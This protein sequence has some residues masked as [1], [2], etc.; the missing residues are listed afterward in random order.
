MQLCQGMQR[1][2]GAYNSLMSFTSLN[3]LGN[4]SELRATTQFIRRRV[5]EF[6]RGYA[7]PRVATV[8]LAF[9]NGSLSRFLRSVPTQ[10]AART[11]IQQKESAP[12]YRHLVLGH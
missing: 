5:E 8:V 9:N 7:F 10:V 11:I 3:G 6:W 2:R 4:S 1:V 12:V